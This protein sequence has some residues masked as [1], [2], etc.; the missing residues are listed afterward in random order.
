MVGETV[1]SAEPVSGLR[2]RPKRFL[3]FPNLSKGAA[4][5]VVVVVVVVVVEVTGTI[6]SLEWTTSIL[7]GGK[8]VASELV[9]ASVLC[10]LE[11]NTMNLFVAKGPVEIKTIE[12]KTN[13]SL[14]ILY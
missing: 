12:F 8:V 6:C 4:S 1:V 10:S 2:V 9:G 7:F 5:V 14:L 3:C 11:P 13:S